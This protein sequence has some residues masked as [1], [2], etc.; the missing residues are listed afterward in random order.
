MESEPTDS[1]SDFLSTLKQ[2]HQIAETK[3]LHIS[4]VTLHLCLYTGMDGTYM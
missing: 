3:V 2:H 4:N 1:T